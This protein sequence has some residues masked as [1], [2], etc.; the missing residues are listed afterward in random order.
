MIRT[1]CTN[2]IRSVTELSGSLW[3][4]SPCSGEFAG[5]VYPVAVPCCWE[6]L[7]DFGAYRGVGVFTKK[8]S[9]SGNIRLVFKG[10]SHTATVYVDGEKVGSHYNA[11]TPFSCLVPDLEEGIHT[12]EVYADNSFS[13]ESALHIPNDYMSYGGISRGVVLEQLKDSFIDSIHA[14]PVR[15]KEGWKVKTSVRICA[16][17]DKTCRLKVSLENGESFTEELDLR[18]GEET[19]V[20]RELKAG[21]VTEW[22]LESPVLYGICAVLSDETGE[23]DD[24]RDRLGF[25]EITVSGKDILLNGR[26]LRIKGFCRHED[27]PQF[28]CALPFAAMEQDLQLLKD[29]G[30]NAVRT[31]HYPNDELFLDLC[32][33]Q[34][35]LVWEEN[36]ARGLSLENMQNPHFEPQAE[37]CIREMITAHIN[38]PSIIIW[39]ILNECASDTEYAFTHCYQKQYDLI[40]QLDD[41]RP[42]SSASCRFK[43][44]LCLG[45]PEIVSYNIYPEWYV[46]QEAASYLSDL[47]DWV[48]NESAG[49]GKPFL[50]TET[51]AGAIYGY[52]T[53][54]KSKWSEEYQAQALRDQITAILNQEGCSGVFIWQL[55][56]VRVS[57]EWF[58]GRPRTMN[59]KGVL[60]EYRR[61][62]LSYDVVKELF[63]AYPDYRE[64]V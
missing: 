45:L 9:A 20:E 11:Y 58:S 59:N 22:T 34:G 48:Q 55:F 51:G 23:Y 14:V 53:P 31:S 29:L 62:K 13:E 30:A 54:V 38:H 5:R 21:D 64:K 1:F 19:V 61:R 50:V 4:F 39:G 16:L 17:A 18:A 56:D 47:Y 26:K 27:H 8:F 2:G 32:D 41:S 37:A 44:D 52:R 36:H 57:S 3:S 42:R 46:N 40:R 25:R 6:S 28:C 12:L 49:A 15:T 43:T 24:L 10:V 63:H 35:I 60:D 7:P 33:E